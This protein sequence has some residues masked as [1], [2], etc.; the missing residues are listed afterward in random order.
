MAL[1]QHIINLTRLALADRVLTYKERATIVDAAIK[2]GVTDDE[3]N[4]YL[5]SALNERL[6]SYT[7]EELKCCP[8]C[9]AQIPLISDMCPYCGN[10]LENI[11]TQR[12]GPPI[13]VIGDDADIIRSENMRV[14]QEKK[15]LKTCPDCGAP[16]PLLSNIC[17][18]CGHILHEQR[19]TELNIKTLI[20]KIEKSIRRL[21]N[22]PIPS[23]LDILMY[24]GPTLLFS[25]A[26]LPSL[27]N[28]NYVF[29]PVWFT[30]I[31]IVLLF[32][33]NIDEAL[34]I[35]ESDDYYYEALY[36]HKMYLRIVKTL[37]GNNKEARD[38]LDSYSSKIKAIKKQRIRN[39]IFLGIDI[40]VFFGFM[41]LF[42]H[43]ALPLLQR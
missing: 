13:L 2:E 36:T 21:K 9:G 32:R 1:S 19:G 12:V 22:I 7:K 43:F 35:Q 14:W 24:Y 26:F 27:I 33:G 34:T 39:I 29:F 20:V 38:L 42:K 11:D 41:L 6:K 3:I 31:S 16:F 18:S 37:Y 17:L 8:A 25:A 23:I 10:Y 5:D 15:N 4:Q 30:V 28:P 40:I